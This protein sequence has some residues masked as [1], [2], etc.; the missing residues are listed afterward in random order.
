MGWISCP[1]GM[2]D[3]KE[4]L[5]A[6][7]REAQ[8]L[9]RELEKGNEEIRRLR[10]RTLEQSEEIRER[11]ARLGEL[12]REV[13]CLKR[14]VDDG[15][16]KARSRERVMR[17]ECRRKEAL[18]SKILGSSRTQSD[19]YIRLEMKRLGERFEMMRRLVVEVSE[20]A[21]LDAEVFDEIA[22]VCEG[23]EDPVMSAF[24]DGVCGSKG[25]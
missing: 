2:E 10:A 22:E 5:D 1:I 18:N 23:F 9:N 13:A 14:R 4:R 15:S 19:Y 16:R 11:D 20:R 8:E 17:T 7:T 12:E 6:L 3:L 21:G 24:L 25:G